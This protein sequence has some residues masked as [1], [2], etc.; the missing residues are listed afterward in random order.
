[1]KHKLICMATAFILVIGVLAGCG[2]KD[3]ATDLGGED[4]FDG[5]VLEVGES[6]ILVEC[7]ACDSGLISVGTQVYVSTETLS[8]EGGMEL[9]A[10]DSVRVVHSGAVMETYPLQLETVYAIYLNEKSA[11][12]E[13]KSGPEGSLGQLP[14]TATG[15]IGVSRASSGYA[16]EDKWGIQ[17]TARDISQTGLTL[18]CTRQ[19][20]EPSGDLQTGSYYSLERLKDG[21]WEAVE[22]LPLEHPLAWTMEAWTIP[23]EQDVKWQE[24]WEWLYGG[25]PAGTYRMGK[26]IM[27]FR[28]PG[29]YDEKM[30]YACFD[31]VDLEEASVISCS[32]GGRSVCLD[33]AEGWEYRIV[34]QNEGDSG[35]GN[36]FGICF[37]PVGE[38]G[39][40]KL[41]YHDRFGVCGTGLK[42]EEITLANGMT[43]AMGTYDNG[44]V[45]SFI[46]FNEPYQGYV[47]LSEGVKDW[48]SQ[49]GEEAMGILGTAQLS[50]AKGE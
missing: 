22:M 4:F 24:D 42:Q 40:V 48:W 33:Y 6:S 14:K 35:S 7:T 10:G 39:W 31:I 15:I 13:V 12:G 27:D 9:S 29:D 21:K 37:R 41:L 26:E 3:P 11:E 36:G 28:G 2:G 23:A 16:S 32:Y 44:E 50:A 17:L 18:V 45:W 1:M 5:K 25:L 38:D 49:Y 20:G 43:G 8:A 46:F 19:G 47:A 34:E 30:Y